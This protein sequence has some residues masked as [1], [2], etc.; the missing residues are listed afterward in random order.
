MGNTE[1]ESHE[2][3]TSPPGGARESLLIAGRSSTWCP[4]RR[5]GKA[6][7]LTP[8]AW[9]PSTPRRPS[10][11]LGAQRTRSGCERLPTEGSDPPT[12][13]LSPWRTQDPAP[14]P[15]VFRPICGFPPS[16]GRI[17]A[18]VICL[19][20]LSHTHR[21]TPPRPGPPGEPRPRGPH[22]HPVLGQPAASGTTAHHPPSRCSPRP[23]GAWGM[24]APQPSQAALASCSRAPCPGSVPPLARAHSPPT[25][26]CPLL[27]TGPKRTT[28]SFALAASQDSPLLPWPTCSLLPGGG[29]TGRRRKAGEDGDGLT[30]Q[31]LTGRRQSAKEQKSQG[32]SKSPCLHAARPARYP[33]RA[34]GWEGKRLGG[35]SR[36][37]GGRRD[38][39]GELRGGGGGAA[40]GRGGAEQRAANHPGGI[41]SSR[42]PGPG[43]GRALE[44]SRLRPLILL[45]APRSLLAAPCWGPPPHATVFWEPLAGHASAAGMKGSQGSGGTRAGALGRPTGQGVRCSRRASALY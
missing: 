4:R 15:P 22:P 18:C 16:Q 41:P 11:H 3:E 2:S 45:A 13:C 9:A 34:G 42:S 28:S 43:A 14:S 12:V 27:P 10:S 32:P 7:A 30:L 40:G 26:R 39:K 24:R 20:Y 8:R 25:L 17:C 38:W 19:S 35:G 21:P 5:N 23:W 36:G 1:A 6:A 44:A 37:G 29:Q 33:W 31:V